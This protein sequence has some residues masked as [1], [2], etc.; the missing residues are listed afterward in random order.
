MYEVA[1]RVVD[2]EHKFSELHLNVTVAAGYVTEDN[3]RISTKP[4]K[5]A[6]T[7][8]HFHTGIGLRNNSVAAQER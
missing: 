4:Q 5:V 1:G 7:Q 3:I 2:P 6:L 8:L